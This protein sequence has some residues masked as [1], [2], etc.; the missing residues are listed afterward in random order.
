MAKSKWVEVQEKIAGAVV[1][2]HQKM[3][4]GV[5]GTYQKLEKGVVGTDQKIEDGFVERF[6]TKDGETAVEAKVRLRGGNTK[7]S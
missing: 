6:L 2:G 5:V 7:S 4:D 1:D 3:E